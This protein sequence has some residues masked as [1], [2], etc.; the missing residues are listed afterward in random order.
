MSITPAINKKIFEIGSFSCFAETLFGLRCRHAVFVASV[1]SPVLLTPVI[2]YHQCCCYWQVIIGG[3]IITNNELI[4][5]VMEIIK[6]LKQGLVTS[7]MTPAI[8]YHQ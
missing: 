1:S 2:Y 5:G 6:N 4:A 7:V 8:I 3:V